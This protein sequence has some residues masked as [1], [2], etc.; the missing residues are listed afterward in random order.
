VIISNPPYVTTEA[1]N[2]LPQEYRRE[3]ELALA[4]GSD[5]MAV[6][7]RLLPQ[8][9]RHLNAGGVLVVEVG[10]GREAVETRW[11]DLALNWITVSEG[12]NLV[13]EAPAEMLWDYFGGRPASASQSEKSPSAE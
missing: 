12:D 11:P 9:G 8:A 2:A 3:P 13:F 5:G 10:D 7:E 6:V 1:M 4:A